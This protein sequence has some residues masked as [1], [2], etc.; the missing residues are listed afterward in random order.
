MWWKWHGASVGQESS[1]GKWD[2]VVGGK[3]SLMVDTLSA[4]DAHKLIVCKLNYGWVSIGKASSQPILMHVRPPVRLSNP[5]QNHSVCL[6][7]F[8]FRSKGKKILC[9]TYSYVFMLFYYFN[10]KFKFTHCSLQVCR[11]GSD[12]HRV[13]SDS[14]APVGQGVSHV[15]ATFQSGCSAWNRFLLQ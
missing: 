5:P 4:I 3:A 8:F 12:D 1:R 9:L 11:S 6:F 14:H 7:V 2:D 15:V 10:T 13:P